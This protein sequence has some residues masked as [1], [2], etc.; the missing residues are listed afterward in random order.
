MKFDQPFFERGQYGKIKG[1]GNPW[2]GRPNAAPFDQPFYIILN[3]AVGGCP[4]LLFSRGMYIFL[5]CVCVYMCMCI[6]I[7]PWDQ[8][9]YIILNVAVGAYACMRLCAYALERLLTAWSAFMRVMYTYM[10]AYAVASLRAHHH[11]PRLHTAWP[12][13]NHVYAPPSTIYRRALQLLCG[14]GGRQA[15]VQQ[16]AKSSY[17]RSIEDWASVFCARASTDIGGGYDRLITLSH[18]PPSPPKDLP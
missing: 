1:T 15:L 17:D 6:R 9:C 18:P 5:I 12:L 13:L 10:C 8:P 7:H 2:A 14:R 4:R 11:P 3:V 16:G